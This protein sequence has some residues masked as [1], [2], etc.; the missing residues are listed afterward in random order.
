M[1]LVQ[2]SI[3]IMSASLLQ[4]V[5]LPD[6]T[7]ICINMCIYKKLAKAMPRWGMDPAAKI[8]LS[9]LNYL[10]LAKWHKVIKCHKMFINQKAAL[11]LRNLNCVNEQISW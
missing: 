10:Y 8:N 6:A 7:S 2:I 3:R 1:E 5:F 4:G 11:P 9:E